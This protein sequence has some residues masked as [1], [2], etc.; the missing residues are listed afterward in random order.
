MSKRR[1]TFAGYQMRQWHPDYEGDGVGA[2][3]RWD[4]CLKAD[5]DYYTEQ[6]K[7]GKAEHRQIR[8]V[9]AKDDEVAPSHF[10]WMDKTRKMLNELM[11]MKVGTRG[12]QRDHILEHIE[13]YPG[14]ERVQDLEMKCVCYDEYVQK[15]YATAY[16][17][18]HQE[19]VRHIGEALMAD[20]EPARAL[21]DK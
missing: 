16:E 4:E 21:K 11:D 10:E 14:N 6:H 2:W 1:L 3:G 18:Q 17:L 15:A 19:A 13:S 5:Y 12:P 9:Y 8:M 7:I 20:L